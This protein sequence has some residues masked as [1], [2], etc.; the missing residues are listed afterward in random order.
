MYKPN[1][2]TCVD[3]KP[4]IHVKLLALNRESKKSFRPESLVESLS[5]N[6]DVLYSL[7]NIM[8]N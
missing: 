1:I 4:N 8:L 2:Y 3:K 5:F 7:I 6:F